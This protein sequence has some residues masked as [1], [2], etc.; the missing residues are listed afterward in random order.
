MHELIRRERDDYKLK[1]DDLLQ[2]KMFGF[3]FDESKDSNEENTN[4]PE[5]SK[6]AGNLK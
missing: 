1:Y 3:N 4:V 6:N 5:V 2:K